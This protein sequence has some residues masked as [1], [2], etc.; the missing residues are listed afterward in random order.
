MII[1]NN[2]PF[3]LILSLFLAILAHALIF[4]SQNRFRSQPATYAVTQGI[5]LPQLNLFNS[6]P[7]PAQ[8]KLTPILPHSFPSEKPSTQ[9]QSA[10]ANF[11]SQT[12]N[13]T[14]KQD[15]Q[16]QSSKNQTSQLKSDNSTS[17]SSKNKKVNSPSASST[18]ASGAI[19][20]AQP[21]YLKNPAPLYPEISRQKQ[22]QGTV[23]I[24]VHVSAGGKP[25]EIKLKQS[26]QFPLLDKAALQAVQRWQFKP[27]RQGNQPIDSFVQIPI[28]FRLSD[29]H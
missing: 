4:F 2:Y 27:A 7:N 28:Q 25:L 8:K 10:Q 12:I 24:D 17:H 15:L 29:A 13:N 26:S 23:L 19:S 16:K 1:Y 11:P 18:D 5:A 3:R 20:L 9:N 6:D 21:D 14:Q 22:Q